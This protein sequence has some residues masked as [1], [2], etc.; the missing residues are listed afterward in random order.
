MHAS[1]KVIVCPIVKD[2]VEDPLHIPLKNWPVEGYV[3]C[4]QARSLDLSVRRF[5]R[6]TA[7]SYF[8]FKDIS[9]EVMGMFDYQQLS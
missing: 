6:I 5:S 9:D 1:G 3:L 8:D 7:A 2:A 4:E